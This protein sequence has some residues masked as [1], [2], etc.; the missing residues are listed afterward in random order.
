[1]YE[2]ERDAEGVVFFS[3][4]WKSHY[5]FFRF[6][7]FLKQDSAMGFDETHER[8]KDDRDLIS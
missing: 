1:M 7:Q 4:S 2:Q 6:Q 3:Q 5:R 8:G